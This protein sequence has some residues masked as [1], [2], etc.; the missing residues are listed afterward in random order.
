VDVRCSQDMPRRRIGAAT[1]RPAT[2]CARESASCAIHTMPAELGLV[3]EALC[4]GRRWH[5]FSAPKEGEGD[6]QNMTLP[7]AGG[8]HASTW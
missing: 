7:G 6:A 1:N 8:W 2:F 5:N 3:L 4:V